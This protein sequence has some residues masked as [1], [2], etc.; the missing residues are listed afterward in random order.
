MILRN[1]QVYDL[2]EIERRHALIT[3]PIGEK[4][5]AEKKEE[6]VFKE[7]IDGAY[8][9]E[10]VVYATGGKNMAAPTSA[11]ETTG[12]APGFSITPPTSMTH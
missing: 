10:E 9:K 5:T 12:D 1:W 8:W 3:L 7:V 11:Q 6:R 4:E 2:K